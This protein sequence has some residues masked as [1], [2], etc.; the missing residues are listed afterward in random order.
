MKK[1]LSIL[2]VS[3]LALPVF[4]GCDQSQKY[5]PAKG[6]EVVSKLQSA[7]SSGNSLDLARLAV[8]QNNVLKDRAGAMETMQKSVRFCSDI[9]DSRERIETYSQI[10]A[11]YSTLNSIVEAK[12]ALGNAME[13]YK[14]W[15]E[16]KNKE[17]EKSRKKVTQGD[18]EMLAGEKLE[19]LLNLAR[20]QMEI[21]SVNAQKT[22]MMA[23]DEAN[24]F[25]DAL[26]KVDKLLDLGA[27]LGK[28]ESFENLQIVGAEVRAILKGEPLPAA[29]S[30]ADAGTE[31]SETETASDDSE[32]SDDSN[33]SASDSDA[34]ADDS[35]A[36]EG[37]EAAEPV[38]MDAQQIGSRL[39]TL[40]GIYV[41]MKNKDAKPV[42]MEILAEA[43]E[44]AKTIDNKGKKAITLCEIGMNYVLAGD[45]EKA[46]ALA[47]EAEPLSKQADS[48]TRE[49]ADEAV[50]NLKAKL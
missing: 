33:V 44:I 7:E 4:T 14:N 2:L 12:K 48:A 32:N 22:L 29:A 8:E 43:A 18:I 9:Q 21:D 49:S 31:G 23:K 3:S 42:G 25:S 41:K 24:R 50:T 20:A 5:N 36:A 37:A 35:E 6:L 30:S 46:K 1:L 19:I 27:A 11:S 10:A 28:M 47:D 40:A 34:S 38:E 15:E 39:S 13:A 26:M 17:R 16:E 45:K